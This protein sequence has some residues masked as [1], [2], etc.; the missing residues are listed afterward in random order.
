M[1]T[2]FKGGTAGLLGAITTLGVQLI[3]NI[4]ATVRVASELEKKG[5]QQAADVAL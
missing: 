1:K 5:C 3:K 4:P 2:F